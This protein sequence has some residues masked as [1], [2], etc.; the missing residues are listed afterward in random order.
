MKININKEKVKILKWGDKNYPKKLEQI[1]NPPKQ[2]YV[3]G[4][5]TIL[6][7]NSVAIIGC[8]EATSYGREIAYYFAREFAKNGIHVISGLARGVDS[9][10]HKGALDSI[11]HIGKTIAVI[12]SGLDTIYPPENFELY[13]QILISGGAIISEYP[14]GTEVKKY[15]FPQRNRIISGLSDGVVVT[16]AKKKSGTLITVE[17]ALQQGKNV[18]AIPRK[19]IK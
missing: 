5:E 18:Y 15:H 1:Y 19:Y 4:D 8:R 10:A 6:N 17:L 3:L 9:Q 13:K 7:Q 2:I 12:G 16:E 11:E 14:L